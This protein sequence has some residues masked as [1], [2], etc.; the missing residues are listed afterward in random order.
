MYHDEMWQEFYPTGGAP[1]YRMKINDGA[2]TPWRQFSMIQSGT[3]DIGAG[4][5]LEPGVVYYCYE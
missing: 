1:W 5:A 3:D 2:F 4:S